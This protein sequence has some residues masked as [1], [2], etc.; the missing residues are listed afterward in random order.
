M[1]QAERATRWKFL[2]IILSAVVL[3]VILAACSGDDKPTQPP[4]PTTPLDI[5]STFFPTGEG[6]VWYYTSGDTLPITRTISGDSS[7]PYFGT[8]IIFGDTIEVTNSCKKVLENG[9][10]TQAWS[11]DS[12]AFYVHLIGEI[13]RPNP[14]LPI[15][16]DLEIDSQ[17]KYWTIFTWSEGGNPYWAADSGTI[18]YRGGVE[19]TV[20]AGVFDTVIKLTYNPAEQ[21][22][23]DEYY[24]RGVGLIDDGDY[25]LDSAFINGI[26]YRP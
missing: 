20:P 1:I 18:V 22:S 5:D 11:K 8:L 4:P 2:S 9:T 14:P 3:T 24:A 17:F 10:T 16:Y 25:R 21:P 13:L 26:W 12:L 7:I 15:P 19:R 23:Y 6:D